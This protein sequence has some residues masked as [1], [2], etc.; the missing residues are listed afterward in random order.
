MRKKQVLSTR[1]LE[2]EKI[3]QAQLPEY[4]IRAN[5]R[6][7]DVIHAGNQF[8]WMSGY[9]LDFIICDESSN[10]IAA[11]EL[12]DSYHD[13]EDGKRK[14]N[15][16]NKWLAQARIKLI[17]IREPQEAINIRELI[18]KQTI[19][20]AS[21]FIQINKTAPIERNNAHKKSQSPLSAFAFAIFMAVILY[22]GT[23]AI[24]SNMRKNV[25]AQQQKLQQENQQRANEQRVAL[26]QVK[27][28]EAW[29]KQQ[30]LEKVEI[31]KRIEAQQPHYERVFVKG[32][33]PAECKRSDGVITDQTIW[34]MKNHYE[35]VWVSGNQ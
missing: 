4:T 11:I 30:E 31:R 12:D 15:N 7:A 34:C 10:T 27:A 28:Q 17:R 35:K 3:L 13:K 2:T 22:F 9:H 6:L 21:S 29:Y 5:I 24:F 14:D 1:E 26:D 25:V 16:K 23:Q 8:K 32:K 33:S 20:D 19:P 18:N